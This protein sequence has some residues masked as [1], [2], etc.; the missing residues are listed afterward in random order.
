MLVILDEKTKAELIIESLENEIQKLKE[1]N[2]ELETAVVARNKI[3]EELTEVNQDITD[4]YEASLCSKKLLE[5]I[6][7]RVSERNYV[8]RMENNKLKEKAAIV[9]EAISGIIN[10]GK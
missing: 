7:K 5:D 8:L 1:I 9:D 6:C 4:R 3:I 10:G 2:K